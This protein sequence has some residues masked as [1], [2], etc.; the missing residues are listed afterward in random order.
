MYFSYLYS[1]KALLILPPTSFTRPTLSMPSY[2]NSYHSYPYSTD[3]ETHLI[4][5]LHCR[6]PLELCRTIK[7]ESGADKGEMTECLRGV[8]QL[9]AGPGDLF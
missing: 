3:A 8:A 6:S 2:H 5:L 1:V 9:F 4:T 7:V